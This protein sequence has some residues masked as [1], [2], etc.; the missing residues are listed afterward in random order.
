MKLRDVL[1][2]VAIKQEAVPELELTDVCY[3]SRH[4]IPGCAFVCIE[5]FKVDGHAFAQ[6][7][8]RDGAA[9]IIAARPLDCVAPVVLVADTRVAL[10]QMGANWF[11]N[12]SAEFKLIGVTGTNG[13]TTT[14]YLLKAILEYQGAK[15]GLI[16]TNQNMIGGTILP[17]ERTTPESFELQRLFAQMRD[18]GAEYVVMEVS[19]HALA[20]HRVDASSFDVGIFTNL[21]QDHLDFHHN[22]EGYRSAKARLFTTCTVGILNADDPASKAILSTATSHNFTFSAMGDNA[23]FTAKNIRL[24][25]GGVEFDLVSGNDLQ[26][27]E[28]PI[29]GKF[30]VYNAL[31]AVACARVLGIDMSIIRAALSAVPGVKGRAEVVKT[32]TDYTVL[33]DYAHTPDGLENILNAVRSFAAGRIITVFGCGGDRDRTKR[34]VMGKL[35]TQLSDLTV[36]TSDNPRTEDPDEIVREVAAGAKGNFVTITDRTQAIRYALSQASPG[37]V[38]LLAGKGHETYQILKD[39]TI[40]YDE[41]EIV[42]QLLAEK[43]QP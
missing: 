18:A 4:V 41:R 6:Q 26:R 38:V 34:P 35:S 20:L 37:D 1:A 19:S 10:A 25:A 31:G 5:G 27:V 22:M 39:R 15:V 32:E 29:P 8:A 2:G 23:D 28:L 11:Q 40:H 9:V 12:P 7:A 16:G 42:H 30:S 36:I 21:T 3:D 13:K 33:I 43:K 14:T 17:T 24:K